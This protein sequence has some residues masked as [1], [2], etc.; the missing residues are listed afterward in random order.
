[1]NSKSTQKISDA[2]ISRTGNLLAEAK[3][4]FM[5]GYATP[6]A[7]VAVGQLLLGNPLTAAVSAV[8]TAVSPV[9]IT[10]AAIG[11]IWMGWRALKPGEQARIQQRHG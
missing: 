10:C 6:I 8:G 3:T 5:I 9:A 11:A 7:I 2:T 1:M 4:G